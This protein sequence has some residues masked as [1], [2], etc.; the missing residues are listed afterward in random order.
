MPT[1]SPTAFLLVKFQ[2]SNEEPISVADATQMFTGAGRGTMNLVDWFDDN[3]HGQVDMT[4][5]AVFGW[6]NLTET[7]A[8]YQAKR[9]DQTYGRTKI[10]DLARDAAS[11]AG[12]NLSPY[13]VHVVVT[14]VE[15][16]LYGGVGFA[17]CTAATA[18]KQFWEIQTAPSVLCQELI[19]GLGV[20]EHSRSHGSDDDY[21]DPY[22]VMSMFAAWPGRS[23]TNA[24][25]PV[26]PGL[27]A[28][29]MK[30]CGWLDPNRAAPAGQAQLRPLHR[31]DLPGPLYAVVGQYY[32]EYRPSRR[33]DT[34]FTSTVLVH[35]LANHTSYLVAE[36]RAG[37][38]AYAWGD[39][40][41]AFGAHG[42]IKVDA[43]DDAAETATITTSFS[44][45]L[46]TPFAHPALSLFPNDYSD[47]VGWVVIGRWVV[48]IPPKWPPI[49]PK[50][51]PFRLVEA[52]AELASLD[53][54]SIP[55]RL[56]T[57]ARAE[58]YARIVAEMDEAREHI[59]GVSSP[60]DH[61]DMEE[62]RRFHE[63]TWGE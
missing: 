36:L 45:T 60:L 51:L 42:S 21:R 38:P 49:P 61:L 54:A 2:G 10:I 30:R 16:D 58:L 40:Q 41:L 46:P 56:E 8:N 43:I 7:V 13:V 22:D 5:N 44:V 23:P 29:F 62:V 35:Y 32:V 53:E 50:S 27:N 48:W 31:R 4:G 14:N 26:G 59:T 6:L 39:P 24:N 25:I 9:Q 19:H 1:P 55:A 47:A 34:G 37:D 33:W 57:E 15:V 3:S 28:A 63:R 17:C 12:I 20:Y 52:A 11:A 18:G